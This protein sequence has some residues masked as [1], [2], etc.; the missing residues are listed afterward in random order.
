MAI[1]DS[2]SILPLLVRGSDEERIRA[3]GLKPNVSLNETKLELRPFHAFHTKDHYEKFLSSQ[4]PQIWN[5]YSDEKSR[6]RLITALHC[7]SGGIM[8]YLLEDLFSFP[9]P[10]LKLLSMPE[11]TEPIYHVLRRLVELQSAKGVYDPFNPAK[12]SEYEVLDILKEHGKG[13]QYLTSQV[14]SDTIALIPNHFSP[15]YIFSTPQTFHRLLGPAVFIS[16]AWDDQA[17]VEPLFQNLRADGCNVQYSPKSDPQ[18][19]MGSTG[20]VSWMNSQITGNTARKYLLFCTENYLERFNKVGSGVHQ[21]VHTILQVIKDEEQKKPQ[22]IA[23]PYLQSGIQRQTPMKNSLILVAKEHKHIPPPI[24][25]LG[26]LYH[27]ST[28]LGDIC[29]QAKDL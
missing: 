25:G 4:Y 13:Y 16:H 9:I 10:Q 15:M 29:H 28:S 8:R 11:P 20:L 3:F 26:L 17:L 7:R 2:A 19:Q 5:Q 12:L 18:S 6:D 1:A 14:D 24:A 23:D 27:S 22:I 21:E